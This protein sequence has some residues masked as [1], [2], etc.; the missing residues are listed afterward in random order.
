MALG[1]G[2]IELLLVLIIVGIPLVAV[3]V[4]IVVLAMIVLKGESKRQG[5]KVQADETRMMQE[6]HHGLSQMEK[7]VE[8]LETILMDRAR[9]EDDRKV[10][11]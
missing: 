4:G 3:I 2:M 1:I 5:K 10:D 7:R 9:R 6:I 11:S 8:T